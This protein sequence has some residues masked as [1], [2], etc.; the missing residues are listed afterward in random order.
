MA[1]AIFTL[2]RFPG[3]NTHSAEDKPMIDISFEVNGRKVL[4]PQQ[5]GQRY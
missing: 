5:Y 4:S 3:K 1:L 2:A